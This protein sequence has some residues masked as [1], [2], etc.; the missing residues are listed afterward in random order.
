MIAELLPYAT[1]AAGLAVGYFIRRPRATS[2]RPPKAVC[3]CGHVISVH[4]DL[5]G[6]CQD[7][8]ERTRWNKFG[9]HTGYEY[10]PCACLRYVGPELISTFTYREIGDAS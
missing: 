9:D 6:A 8:T 4:A 7:E 10:V 5:T 1:G 2:S 3:P